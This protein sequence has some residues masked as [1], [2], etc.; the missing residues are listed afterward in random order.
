[1]ET[2]HKRFCVAGEVCFS[3]A[4]DDGCIILDVRQDSILSLNST[5]AFMFAKLAASENGMTRAELLVSIAEEF[6]DVPQTRLEAAVDRLVNQL[7]ERSIIHTRI[8]HGLSRAWTRNNVSAACVFCLKAVINPLLRMKARAAAALI[9][10]TSVDVLLKVGGFSTLHELVKRWK[11]RQLSLDTTDIIVAGCA[12]VEKACIWHPKEKLCLQ[13][14]AVATCL[15]R[16][17]GVPAEMV[18][19]IHK[20][21]FYGHSWVEVDGTVVNDHKNVQ[22]FFEVISR[23]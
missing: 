17:L 7:I 16:S 13:R 6:G 20:M 5:G 11:L 3:P 10:L 23:C 21:P 19:G 12:T 8:A 15:L 4:T 9:L 1:M 2:E 18:I 14:S 22:T